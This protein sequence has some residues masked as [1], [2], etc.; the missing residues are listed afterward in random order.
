MARGGGGRGGGGDW[1][2]AKLESWVYMRKTCRVFAFCTHR[3]HARAWRLRMLRAKHPIKS[4][5]DIVF[6]AAK[7]VYTVRGKAVPISVTKLISRDAVPAEHA[8]DG[9]AV[10]RKN[11]V[12]WRANASS[13][14]HPLVEGVTDEE[15]VSNV[16]GLWDAN[17]DA[18]TAMHALF[19]DTLNGTTPDE[20]GYEVEMAQFRAAMDELG[21]QGMTP[22]RT[23]LSIFA[24]G[25][26]G[27]AV[28]AGQIDLLV[29]DED[30]DYHLVDYKRTANDLRP[31]APCWGK[32]FL[33]NLPLNDHHKYSL[34]LSLYAQMFWQQT[35]ERILSCRL[36][37]IHPDLEAHTWIH[38]SDMTEH[39]RILLEN[40]GV[41]ASWVPPMPKRRRIEAT[42]AE[43]QARAPPTSVWGKCDEWKTGTFGDFPELS[44]QTFAH[45]YERAPVELLTWVLDKANGAGTRWLADFF[46]YVHMRSKAEGRRI[47]RA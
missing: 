31:H 29:K 26:E 30:G 18:G 16:L 42:E 32:R 5:D 41:E 28:I 47:P 34:Q 1:W 25:P 6:D 17:R 3:R 4:D 24:N 40:I 22:V 9:P 10:V 13:K 27:R 38:T 20:A 21:V 19:E 8:F 45:V 15:A 39:A 14:F 35:G 37:Q 36:L 12:S 11:L 33:G 46:R 43:R 23:E 44:Q 7:H 2:H